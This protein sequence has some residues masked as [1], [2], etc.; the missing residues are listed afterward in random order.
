MLLKALF[1]SLAIQPVFAR[2]P[3]FPQ[4]RER[5]LERLEERQKPA[6]APAPPAAFAVDWSP[7]ASPFI[8]TSTVPSANHGACPRAVLELVHEN[9]AYFY[10]TAVN[11]FDYRRSKFGFDYEIADMMQDASLHILKGS[12]SGRMVYDPSYGDG[13]AH[14]EGE[15]L[16]NTG[17]FRAWVRRQFRTVAHRRV[18]DMETDKRSAH[19]T[20]PLTVTN[21]RG[22]QILIT[23]IDPR[24][25]NPAH[26]VFDPEVRAFMEHEATLALEEVDREVAERLK[27]ILAEEAAGIDSRKTLH[28]T[29]AASKP[30]VDPEVWARVEQQLSE[31]LA[32]VSLRYGVSYSLF[33]KDTGGLY[34]SDEVLEFLDAEAKRYY[35][36]LWASSTKG[37]AWNTI[38]LS[39]LRKLFNRLCGFDDKLEAIFA[40]LA[41]NK[42]TEMLPIDYRAML[43]LEPGMEYLTRAKVSLD[44]E[45]KRTV[46]RQLFQQRQERADAQVSRL[47]FALQSYGF[48]VDDRMVESEDF[49]TSQR[50]RVVEALELEVMRLR[51][52]PYA[53]RA[54][55]DLYAH[56][57]VGLDAHED[58]ALAKV[59]EMM[60][61][62]LD[63][64]TRKRLASF[65]P[66]A[67][68]H[69]VKSRDEHIQHIHP[70][71]KLDKTQ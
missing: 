11:L 42:A 35:S 44:P 58:L 70:G 39:G 59:A 30:L 37:R 17:L 14:V 40:I 62:A 27:R 55:R 41:K 46:S 53:Q 6:A 66:A 15:P 26:V 10:N 31:E 63:K 60:P 43:D 69:F 34:S 3:L 36:G 47:G 29:P 51:I 28:E 21:E 22:R 5:L 33:W 61:E 71:T 12:A 64:F 67:P 52:F 23:D 32:K 45:D 18:V 2:A 56:F 19:K 50:W 65:D 25:S 1:V 9:R 13:S 57:I 8:L 4:L 20:K 7:P 68:G 38:L 48:N 49:V 16:R 54:R 24:F